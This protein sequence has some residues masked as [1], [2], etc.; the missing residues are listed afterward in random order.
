MFLNP[1][2]K[3]RRE[4]SIVAREI[5]KSFRS[6][7]LTSE[8]LRGIDI[9]VFPGELTLLMGPSGSGKTTLLG[10]LGGLLSATTGEVSVLG[11][12]LA[13][14]SPHQLDRFRLQNCGF[15]FQGFNLFAALTA[16]EQIMLM[17][18]Y[19]GIHGEQAISKASQA[20]RDVHL[21]EVAHLR[22]NEL[23][24]GQNQRVAIARSMV[25]NPRLIFADEPTS[26]LDS[27]SGDIVIRLL[28]EA[29]YRLDATVLVV[30][31]DHRLARHA[32]RVL[33]LEDGRIVNDERHPNRAMP[34][35]RVE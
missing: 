6:G 28:H 25:K 8:V 2:P 16:Q 12:K 30:T 27:A 22:P 31:H 13:A 11:K 7:K 23:S 19:L 32:D 5:T 9:E 10:V 18:K 24:G 17:L 33:S 26:A 3:L 14:F 1:I 4:P 20:L 15:V 29:A 21:S 35:F 34:S